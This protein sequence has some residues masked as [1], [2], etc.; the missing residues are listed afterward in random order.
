MAGT[1]NSNIPKRFPANVHT[2]AD[3]LGGIGDIYAGAKAISVK[4]TG[5]AQGIFD[6]VRIMPGETFNYPYCGTSY[7]VI[8]F[9]ATG[10]T[11][12]IFVFR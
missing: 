8:S 12:K 1:L 6:G 2:E 7:G 9:D 3:E 4:N 11:F 5:A 10:T